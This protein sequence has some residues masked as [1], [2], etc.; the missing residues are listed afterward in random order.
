MNRR[1]QTITRLE[2]ELRQ[3]EKRFLMERYASLLLLQLELREAEADGGDEL[4]DRTI[5]SL[6]VA[7]H[8]AGPEVA[9]QIAGLLQARGVELETAQDEDEGDS[10]FGGDEDD[11]DAGNGADLS[12]DADLALDESEDEVDDIEGAE[13]GARDPEDPAAS[14]ELAGEDAEAGAEGLFDDGAEPEERAG[15]AADELL[16]DDANGGLGGLFEDDAAGGDDADAAGLLETEDE[17]G[18]SAPELDEATA[19]VAGDLLEGG[20]AQA[21]G[22]FDEEEDGGEDGDGTTEAPPRRE[23]RSGSRPEADDEADRPEAGEEDEDAGVLFKED[24]YSGHGGGRADAQP[25]QADGPGPPPARGQ[26]QGKTPGFEPVQGH[27]VE[28]T[29]GFEPVQGHEI[30][31]TP[32][33]KPGPKQKPGRKRGFE[34]TRGHQAKDTPGFEPSEGKRP[35]RSKGCFT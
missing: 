24:I 31:E 1:T 32:G 16:D 30:E 26:K 14:L 5:E 18:G 21:E 28:E 19:A 23:P 8:Y 20:D 10:L 7:H 12:L 17:S 4:D 29:P 33:F 15:D 9:E 34:P 3:R 25:A 2:E 6:Q 11:G 35:A 22:L 27:Q 13:P